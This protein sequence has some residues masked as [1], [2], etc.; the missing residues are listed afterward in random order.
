LKKYRRL[1]YYIQHT[2]RSAAT[3][4][5]STSFWNITEYEK[6]EFITSHELLNDFEGFELDIPSL[7]GNEKHAVA[8]Q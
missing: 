7:G 8:Q 3:T 5:D 1:T 4:I 2:S 6:L